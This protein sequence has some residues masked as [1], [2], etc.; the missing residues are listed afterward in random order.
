MSAGE[1]RTFT[2]SQHAALLMDAVSRETAAVVSERD[3]LVAEKAA[4]AGQVESLTGDNTALQSR[5]D[6]LE[7]EK[8]AAVQQ[9]QA[10]QEEFDSFKR[11]LEEMA[12]MESRKADRVARLKAAAGTVLSDDYLGDAARQ[13]RWAEMADEAFEALV[14]SLT[15]TAKAA[16]AKTDTEVTKETARETAA[17]KGGHSPTAPNGGSAVGAFLGAIRP[18]VAA[19]LSPATNE[20]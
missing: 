3:S 9:A 1:E 2:E 7:A 4:L 15:E 5:L 18:G 10:T 8:A 17:F 13:T 6:V 12:A 11:G 20:S 19:V 14:E 16:P